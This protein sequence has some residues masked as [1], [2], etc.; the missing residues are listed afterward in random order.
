MSSTVLVNEPNSEA[1]ERA[2]AFLR[3]GLKELVSDLVQLTKPRIVV[4]ILVTTVATAM[5][6]AGGLVPMG[7]MLLLLIGTGMVAGSAGGANQIWER[8]IDRNMVRTSVRPLPSARMSTGVA[9]AFTASC[10][11]TSKPVS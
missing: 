3:A 7:T 10:V 8:V 1:S 9:T 4:M 6:A 5:I 11:H 2:A